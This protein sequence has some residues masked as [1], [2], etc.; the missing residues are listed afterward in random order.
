MWS[1]SDALGWPMLDPCPIN[2]I[3]IEFE[4][5]L[6]FVMDLFIAYSADHNEIL[7]MSRQ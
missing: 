3:L 2:Y 5:Q 6:N 1:G 4:I 7:H